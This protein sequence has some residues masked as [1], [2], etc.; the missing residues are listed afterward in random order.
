MTVP[1][2]EVGSSRASCA[3]DELATGGGTTVSNPGSNQVN[4]PDVDFGT[5]PESFGPTDAPTQWH[6][7][8]LNPGPRSLDILSYAEGAKLVNAP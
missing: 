8:L 2:G 6:F 7:G 1:A 3:A 5:R 4:E